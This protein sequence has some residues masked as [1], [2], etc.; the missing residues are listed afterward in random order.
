MTFESSKGFTKESTRSANV[1]I[2]GCRRWYVCWP[3]SYCSCFFQTI[4]TGRL[5]AA[6]PIKTHWLPL[7]LLHHFVLKID[8]WY[9]NIR[10]IALQ[11]VFVP[12]PW[13]SNIPF[14]LFQ[15]AVHQDFRYPVIRHSQDMASPPQLGLNK[16]C[17]DSRNIAP[18]E[19]VN[20]GHSVL[21]ANTA[22]GMQ[23]A[24]MEDIQLADMVPVWC[25]QLS[26]TGGQKG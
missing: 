26:R 11:L 22:N 4:Q 17:L 3:F 25:P 10:Q 16:E 18:G 15:L 7:F 23:T 9:A 13:A 14:P 19:Q 5:E 20:I 8:V 2:E 12:E 6:K 1:R 21:K 24:F